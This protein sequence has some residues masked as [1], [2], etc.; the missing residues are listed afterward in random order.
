MAD[1]LLKEQSGQGA[2][3][4]RNTLEKFTDYVNP[5]NDF[6]LNKFV[7]RHNSAEEAIG[8]GKCLMMNHILRKKFGDEIFLQ[9]YRKFYE[10]NKFK[11][12]SFDD[13]KIAF[14]KTSNTNLKD[15][16]NLWTTSKGAP[17]LKLYDAKKISLENNFSI[18]FKILQTQKD[19]FYK[20]DIPIAIYFADTVI[21]K[22]VVM[23]NPDKEFNF[24]FAVE[25]LKIEVDP[26]F[27]IFRTI[28]RAEVPPTLSQIFGSKTSIIILPSKSKFLKEYELMA[29]I[30]KETQESQ[31]NILLI[32]YDENLSLLP[33]D[34][35][36]WIFGFENKFAQ[37]FT[38]DSQYKIF[39]APIT[40]SSEPNNE[41]FV[42]VKD[43]GAKTPITVGY[44][45]T[46]NQN[47]ISGLGRLLPHYGKYSYL[48]FAGDRP[49][50]K[51]KGNF[52]ASKSPL[53]F[54]FPNNISAIGKNV[55]IIPDAA[56]VQP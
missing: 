7:N 42:M 39:A 10:D 30:W 22:N 13:I 8:Y 33:E 31:E 26:Q 21:V 15:F 1:H 45:A 9:S 28:D 38:S 43:F 32:K 24:K 5:E 23:D 18:S 51:L 29:K 47:A 35:A 48:K 2:E 6:P 36:F 53:H 54:S 17:S 44:I 37:I 4:R 55:K 34:T 16:F 40:N 49:D 3:Y 41:S 14:E 56:L 50:N 27:D 12:A 20:I 11:K 19:V 25:P 46:Y 52:A